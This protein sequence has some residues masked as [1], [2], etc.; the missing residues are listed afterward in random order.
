MIKLYF[1]KKT[2]SIIGANYLKSKLIKGTI[3]KDIIKNIE[4]KYQH[5]IEFKINSSNLLYTYQ[6]G[7]VDKNSFNVAI[8]HYKIQHAQYETQLAIY[9][10]AEE[11]AQRQNSNTHTR[12][13]RP[14][15]PSYPNEKSFVEWGDYTRGSIAYADNFLIPIKNEITPNFSG[16][17]KSFAEYSKYSIPINQI[18]ESEWACCPIEK[19]EIKQLFENTS[20]NK[21]IDAIS[22]SL[23]NIYHRDIKCIM[24]SSDYSYVETVLP[25]W[26]LSYEDKGI[27]KKIYIDEVNGLISGETINDNK[28]LITS[29][30]KHLSLLSFLIF[31]LDF[32]GVKEP[33]TKALG[34]QILFMAA[35]YLSKKIK[36]SKSWIIKLSEFFDIDAIPKLFV[37]PGTDFKNCFESIEA[38]NNYISSRNQQR[39]IIKKF[40]KE[41]TDF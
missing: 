17:F 8:E 10:A 25:V 41:Y 23:A 27:I 15:P 12:I 14:Y 1:D 29:L 35:L 11:A 20:D 19:K 39:I 5:F 6:K 13:S 38:Y 36:T 21:L 18:N 33:I 34:C 32:F 4:L 2:I 24:T 16:N 26:Q 30:I 37:M 9:Q 28:V 7:C 31:G 22:K 40:D 3:N